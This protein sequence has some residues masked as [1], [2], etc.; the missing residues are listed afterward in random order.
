MPKKSTGLFATGTS[1]FA[2]VCVIGRSRVPAPPDRIKPLSG[3]I[4]AKTIVG[5]LRPSIRCPAMEARPRV[6]IFDW[7]HVAHTVG[8]TSGV[9]RSLEQDADVVIAAPDSVL[10]Q[11]GEVRA[12]R[13]SLGEARPPIKLGHPRLG[14]APL[15]RHELELMRTVCEDVKPDLL[16]HTYTDPILRWWASA[17]PLP[18]PC[19]AILHFPRNQMAHVYGIRLGWRERLHARFKEHNL[20]RWRRRSDAIAIISHDPASVKLWQALPGAP[21]FSI[22]EPPLLHR[23]TPRPPDRRKGTLMFGHLDARKGI[24][25]IAR[26]LSEDSAGLTVEFRGMLDPEYRETYFAS[27]EMMRRGGATVI[28]RAGESDY[29]EAMERMASA[30]S[31]LL[32]FGWRPT[33]SRVLLEAAAAET[34]VIVAEGSTVARLVEKR[35]LGLTVNPDDP[36]AIRRAI[37]ELESLAGPRAEFRESLRTYAD[38]C[39]ETF[40]SQL[41]LALGIRSDDRVLENLETA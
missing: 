21:A 34:P 36:G 20:A 26:D 6:C 41:L 13:V 23:P 8:W 9:A 5:H 14:K 3:A 40:S 19:C 29:V 28:D 7:H 24:D 25:L 11:L 18:A 37:R 22:P 15:A 17:P 33:G 4:A 16:L 12:E 38:Y 32:S 27:L 39:S 1:C 35:R 31:A 2:D 10:E 30:S